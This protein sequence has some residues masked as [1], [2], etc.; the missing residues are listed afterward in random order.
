M[1]ETNGY[2]F[3]PVAWVGVGHYC[4]IPAP[5]PHRY[6]DIGSL[7]P[8]LRQ[9]PAQQACFYIYSANSVVSGVSG[10]KTN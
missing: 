7:D 3:P 4:F 5:A 1:W 9:Q 2:R 10:I 6:T 8:G